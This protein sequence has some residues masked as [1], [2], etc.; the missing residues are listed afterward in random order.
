MEMIGYLG[1]LLLTVCG[2]PEV[3][4]TIKD[5][6]CHLGWSM[7]VL[8]SLGEV[9]MV[10]YAFYL[11]NGPL[12]MNYVFNFFVVGVMLFYKI[13]AIETNKNRRVKSIKE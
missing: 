9:F 1:S 5:N 13:K 6:K 8:W 11:G 4:R 7:I 12:I 10:V 3:I 2:I